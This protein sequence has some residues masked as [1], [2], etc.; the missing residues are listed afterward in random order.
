[1]LPQQAKS[2]VSEKPTLKGR[3]ERGGAFRL[4]AGPERAGGRESGTD[5]FWGKAKGGRKAAS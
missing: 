4:A 5:S 3:K 2:Q 1:M